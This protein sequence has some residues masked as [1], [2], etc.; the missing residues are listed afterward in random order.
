MQQWP[1]RSGTSGS[2]QGAR[3]SIRT[4]LSALCSLGYFQALNGDAASGIDKIKKA[5]RLSPKDF[6]HAAMHKD[7]ALACVLGRRYAEGLEPALVATNESPGM[8]P[9]HATL[10]LI[11]VGLG[12][13]DKARQ[14]IDKLRQIA[15]SPP[16]P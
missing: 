16:R 13:F 15:P 1:L 5:I 8:A 10:A 7:L 11:Y 14:T 6:A 9:A 12:E 4:L 3:A 2:L